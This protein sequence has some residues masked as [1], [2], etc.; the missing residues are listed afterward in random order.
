[1]KKISTLS[2]FYGSDFDSYNLHVQLNFMSTVL[3]NSDESNMHMLLQKV[4]GLFT[5]QKSLINEV[6]SCHQRCE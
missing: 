1:M 5:A 2:E 3:L 4:K 6:T